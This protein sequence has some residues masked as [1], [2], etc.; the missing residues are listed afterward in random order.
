MFKF[1][2]TFIFLDVLVFSY[3]TYAQGVKEEDYSYIKF[4]P[5]YLADTRLVQVSFR[6]NPLK[7][8]AFMLFTPESWVRIKDITPLIS[9]LGIYTEQDLS[10]QKNLYQN[11][12]P[13]VVIA[14][15]LDAYFWHK[16][17]YSYRAPIQEL[18]AYT[19][20]LM[21]DQYSTY[22]GLDRSVLKDEEIYVKFLEE[23]GDRE[24]GLNLQ[25]PYCESPNMKKSC[26]FLKSKLANVDFASVTLD[27][28]K[29]P[30]N[31][32]VFN[33]ISKPQLIQSYVMARRIRAI[34][35]ILELSQV[36]A[37]RKIFKYTTQEER[38]KIIM[39]EFFK[40]LWDKVYV[41]SY[42]DYC[43][44]PTLICNR[45]NPDLFQF[46]IDNNNIG[47]VLSVDFKESEQETLIQH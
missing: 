10:L 7:D 30:A 1:I 42:A 15:A 40:E 13:Y 20:A 17:P 37:Q 33:E 25:W 14:K 18:Q 39:K 24:F 11:L 31:L 34:K 43:A 9:K 29:L 5:I 32:N 19:Q 28:E 23:V 27:F 2:K 38:N 41:F 46:L 12:F 16:Y 8:R 26:L 3:L 35:E 36:S 47:L 21:L 22:K 45:F 44:F 6:D 4:D